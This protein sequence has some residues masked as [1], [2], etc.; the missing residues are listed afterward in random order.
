MVGGLVF[1]IITILPLRGYTLDLSEFEGAIRV[2][3]K[4]LIQ[5]KFGVEKKAIEEQEPVIFGTPVASLDTTLFL[6]ES[7]YAIF[8]FS[9]ENETLEIYYLPDLG[10]TELAWEAIDYAP[11]WLRYDLIDNFMRMDGTYQDIYANLIL[12]APDLRLVDEIAFQVAHISPEILIDSIFDP[13]L[14]VINASL[15]YEYDDSLDYVDVIDFGLP[16][17]SDDYYTTLGYYMTVDGDT[18]PYLLPRD[19]YYYYVLH[20]QLSD[21]CPRMDDYVYNQFWREFYYG[22]VD[23]GYPILSEKLQGVRILW[24]NEQHVLPG[25]RPYSPDDMALDVVAHWVTDLVPS[26]ACGNRPIQ[27]NVVIYEHNGN[28]GELQD[29]LAAAGRT[30]LIPTTSVFT[31][32]EDH[33]WNE[34]YLNDDWHEYQVDLG[35]GST[36]IDDPSTGYD[37]QYGGS[38]DLSSVMEWRSDGR[39][40]TVTSRYSNTCTLRI[41]VVDQAG[42]PVDGARILLYSDYIYGGLSISCWG[43][44]NANGECE[45]Q[46]GEL[47]DF[48]MH[49]NSPIGDYPPQSGDVIQIIETSQTGALYE[50]TFVLPGYIPA[51]RPMVRP[52]PDN[53]AQYVFYATCKGSSILHG[54]ARV[55]RNTGDDGFYHTYQ[56]WSEMGPLSIYLVDSTGLEQYMNQWTFT[57]LNEG[58]LREVNAP[59]ERLY[60]IVSNREMLSTTQTFAI[61]IGVYLNEN[62][63]T[64]T[65]K[66]EGG[67]F[68]DLEAYSSRKSISVDFTV[69]RGKDYSLFLYDRT[70][71]LVEEVKSGVGEGDRESL[72]LE[73]DIPTGIYFLLLKTNGKTK[74]RKVLWLNGGGR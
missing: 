18:V 40:R 71:R 54:Y 22:E 74:V 14:I 62:I 44:T 2:V 64:V 4:E 48:Y 51:P 49:I 29:A 9:P 45:F 33:T 72:K 6:P 21:E 66:S 57:S 53:L 63:R 11:N 52:C 23:S 28:C 16:P 58:D 38:K 12:E 61:N 1:W 32:A 47:R 39:V 15:I 60:V 46:L 34:F 56:E 26:A 41:K 10:L 55:R 19:Y 5:P 70:G 65:E 7:S 24:D 50:K 73:P 17:W 35:Y 43:F 37:R 13:E 31:L 8:S 27:P 67:D 20:P 25:N 69:P 3:G 42:R 59:S 68:F 30:A 36:H